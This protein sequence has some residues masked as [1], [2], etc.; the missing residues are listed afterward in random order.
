MINSKHL[1]ESFFKT[2]LKRLGGI[3]DCFFCTNI[4]LNNR[5]LSPQPNNQPWVLSHLSNDDLIKPFT[6]YV[7]HKCYYEMLVW[8]ALSFDRGYVSPLVAL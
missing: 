3:S 1:D 6:C 4:P 7:S 8:V 2:R 5:K